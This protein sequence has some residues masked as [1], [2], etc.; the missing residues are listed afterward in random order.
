MY[1]IAFRVD[2]DD[3]TGFGHLSRCLNFCRNAIETQYYLNTDFIFVG[4]FN[5]FSRTLLGNF[6]FNYQPCVGLYEEEKV[7]DIPC[8]KVVIDSYHLTQEK[9]NSYR[10]EFEKVCIIDDNNALDFHQIDLVINFRIGAENFFKYQARKVALGIN[11]FQTKPELTQIRQDKLRAYRQREDVRKILVFMG[12]K[13]ISEEYWLHVLRAIKL[14]TG[15]KVRVVCISEQSIPE[16]GGLQLLT[17]KP[18][19]HIEGLLAESDVCINGGGL[20]KYEAAFCAIPTASF[21]T[22]ELQDKDT[23]YLAS[24]G[25]IV[26]LGHCQQHNQ[27]ELNNGVKRLICDKSLRRSLALQSSRQFPNHSAQKLIHLFNSVM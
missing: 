9:L 6:G 1:N 5:S 18:T 11:Y 19:V 27:R 16:V 10:L 8:S 23:K 15:D 26:D 24:K 12:G 4:N 17:V 13:N 20:I 14:A 25:L 7:I 22:T 3:V 2:C 21:S